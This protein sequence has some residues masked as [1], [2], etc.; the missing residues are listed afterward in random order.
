M[1]A[2]RDIKSDFYEFDEEHYRLVGRRSGHIYCL[3]DSVRIKVKGTNLEQ[4]ILDFELVE[5][6][7]L[8]HG[9]HSYEGDSGRSRQEFPVQ[10]DKKARKAK[11]ARAI[12]ESKQ[13]RNK[14]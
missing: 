4:R 12:K 10:G 7:E 9:S 2:L 11:I 14:G 6:E 3:G 1:M 8:L 5:P 13:R